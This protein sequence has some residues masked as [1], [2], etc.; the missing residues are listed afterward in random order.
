MLNAIKSVQ[1]VVSIDAATANP[2]KVVVA[3]SGIREPSWVWRTG[4]SL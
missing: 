3:T 2:V 4:L 1:E